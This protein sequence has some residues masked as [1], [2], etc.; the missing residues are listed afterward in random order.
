MD[1]KY[2][3]QLIERYWRCE[4]S[5]EEEAILRA[6]FSQEDIPGELSTY[7]E[8]FRLE[9]QEVQEDVLGDAFDRKVMAAIAAPTTVKAR[10]ITMTERLKPLFK[11]AAVVAIL[12]TLGNAVQVPFKDARA[13]CQRGVRRF[14]RHRLRP[15][16]QC[17]RGGNAGVQH[18]QIKIISMLSL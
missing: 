5:L 3:N 11:A 7:K 8:L 14:G 4:T 9:R 1:Y 13:R 12:L 18:S 15:T 6:F 10:T 17:R 16:H 2:I